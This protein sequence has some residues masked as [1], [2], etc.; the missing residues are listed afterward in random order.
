MRKA[1]TQEIIQCNDKLKEAVFVR[2][3]GTCE[4]KDGWDDEKIAKA[5][6]ADMSKLSVAK[7]RQEMFGNLRKDKGKGEFGAFK[8][9]L[10]TL[11]AQHHALAVYHAKLIDTLTL[12]KVANVKHLRGDFVTNEGKPNGN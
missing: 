5:I 8:K 7:I 2:E 3:D 11:E 4:Y 9:R 6:S 12:N 1:T 10:E